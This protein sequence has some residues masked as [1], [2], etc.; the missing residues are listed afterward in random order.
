MDLNTPQRRADRTSH[1]RTV[2]NLI[3]RG[4]TVTKRYREIEERLETFNRHKITNTVEDLA[5]AVIEGATG[6]ELT[7]FIVAVNA[8]LSPDN[9]VH[10][11]AVEA[12]SQRLRDEYLNHSAQKNYD[13]A[14]EAYNDLAAKFTAAHTTTP[15][16]TPASELV[17]ASAKQREAW[18]ETQTLAPQLSEAL[19]TLRIAA[20]A[21]TK[22]SNTDAELLGLALIPNDANR[23]DV[24][25][26]W[27]RENR[28]GD[29][30]DLGVTL[31]AP[32]LDAL[33]PYAEPKPLV[34]RQIATPDG[35]S[36]VG[37]P[38]YFYETATFDPERLDEHGN[39]TRVG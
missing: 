36:N 1:R 7:P 37:N 38:V 21:T 4:G 10:V 35:Y 32:T 27:R 15:T 12:I 20:L 34:Q 29:L 13:A 24:W 25:E 11:A 31:Q 39:P 18:L 16:N 17:G 22:Y 28:W 30:I 19:N 9:R 2:Q 26:A 23:R 5:D 6:S 33:E 14:R 8:E 3:K